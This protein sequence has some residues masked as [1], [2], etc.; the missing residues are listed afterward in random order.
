MISTP[1]SACSRNPRISML[2]LDVNGN[3]MVNLW[4]GN[5]LVLVL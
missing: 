1:S 2:T 5:E 3:A 4:S